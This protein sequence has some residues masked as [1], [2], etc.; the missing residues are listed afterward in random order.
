MNSRVQLIYGIP[1]RQTDI[2]KRQTDKYLKT[3]ESIIGTKR[4]R[5]RDRDSDEYMTYLPSDFFLFNK[6]ETIEDTKKRL[7]SEGTGMEDNPDLNLVA[8]T[9]RVSQNRGHFITVNKDDDDFKNNKKSRT[10]V[11]DQTYHNIVFDSGI[12]AR[13]LENPENCWIEYS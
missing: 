9:Q 11:P 2:P 4:D 1:N 7:G 12:Y 5:D 13:R 10:G 8:E 6:Q 3:K